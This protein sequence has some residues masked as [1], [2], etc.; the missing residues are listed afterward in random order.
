MK[1]GYSMLLGEYLDA[2]GINYTDCKSFQVVCPACK[3]PIF[4]VERKQPPP[5]L[6]YLS[7]YERDKAYVE[8]CELRVSR[9]TS[10]EMD[11][12]TSASRNQKLEYFL[13]VLR[14]AIL[15]TVF[16]TDA[17]NQQNSRRHITKMSQA[18][19]VQIFRDLMLKNYGIVKDKFLAG[20]NECLD[21]YVRDVTQDGEDFP[22]TSFSIA[23]QKRIAKD[24]WSHL[25][26]S[27]A[28]GNFTFLFSAGYIQLMSRI[29]DALKIR[30]L[31]NH[32][33]LMLRSLA[34]LMEAGRK[35]AEEIFSKLASTSI[36]PP[37]AL[38]GMDMFS[39][40]AAEIAH[41]MLGI[42][43][44]IPYFELLK[45]ANRQGKNGQA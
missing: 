41:E 22:R 4:K 11:E 28:K 21:D 39:K 32:E 34:K 43:I 27:K 9:M 40:T 26:S 8:E 5:T 33:I 17:V 23:T 36:G 38:A 1:V 37:F 20:M 24:I 31:H 7:H 19:G 18:A 14:E 35:R 16:G 29:D 42:L 45:N 6:H 15:E 12:V 10:K 25:I 44:R 3:E 2:T 30:S 13:S